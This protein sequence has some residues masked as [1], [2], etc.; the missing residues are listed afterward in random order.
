MFSWTRRA[1]SFL[2][3]T[4]AT[5]PE[6]VR[7]V[8]RGLYCRSLLYLDVPPFD[9][10]FFGGSCLSVYSSATP[11]D[12]AFLV[13]MRPVSTKWLSSC[14]SIGGMS[15]RPY[16]CSSSYLFKMLQL[17]DKH[18]QAPR[19]MNLGNVR[20]DSGVKSFLSMNIYRCIYV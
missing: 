12:S 9:L 18:T 7:S 17:H 1:V 19:A 10:C 3:Q 4:K 16:K 15:P 8:W 2:W 13:Y 20:K 14:Q 11:S 6:C 5:P